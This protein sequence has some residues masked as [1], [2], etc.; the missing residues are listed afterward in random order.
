MRGHFRESE[1]VEGPPHRAEIRVSPG[2][3]CHLPAGGARE[4][5]PLGDRTKCQRRNTSWDHDC[6]PPSELTRN[7]APYPLPADG[8]PNNWYACLLSPPAGSTQA[9]PCWIRA[10]FV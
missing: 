6:F 4:A 10:Y 2:A 1:L 5:A 3:C 9:A 8:M 7:D